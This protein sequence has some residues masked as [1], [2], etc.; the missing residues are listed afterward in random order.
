[1]LMSLRSGFSIASSAGR[2]VLNQ[3]V[4]SLFCL[5]KYA[6]SPEVEIPVWIKLNEPPYKSKKSTSN[7]PKFQACGELVFDVTVSSCCFICKKLTIIMHSTKEPMPP[8]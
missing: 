2:M 8:V 7:T 1:M 4:E 5:L 6:P 3:S